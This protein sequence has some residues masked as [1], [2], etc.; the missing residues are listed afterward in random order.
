MQVAASSAR[1]PSRVPRPA[2]STVYVSAPYRDEPSLEHDVP[3]HLAMRV[4]MVVH[5]RLALAAGVLTLLLST[6]ATVFVGAFG[7]AVDATVSWLVSAAVVVLAFCAM[8]RPGRETVLLVSTTELGWR[9]GW[10]E[11]RV[12]RESGLAVLVET[13]GRILVGSDA[14]GRTATPDALRAALVAKGWGVA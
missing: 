11:H 4:G 2:N 1:D 7:V 8:W 9:T 13:D 10:V 6:L 12:V 5:A 3:R 14:I